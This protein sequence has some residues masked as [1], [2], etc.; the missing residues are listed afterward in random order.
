MSV[1]KITI[2]GDSGTGKSSIM[3]RYVNNTFDNNLVST[4][5]VEFMTKEI[6]VNGRNAK[7]QIWDTAGQER[8][9]AI[10]R[11]IYHGSKAIIIVYDITNSATFNSLEK[12]ISDSKVHLP[13]N[14]PYFLVGNKVDLDHLRDVKTQ[15]AKS[16]A[17]KFEM[18]F[19]ETSAATNQNISNIFEM[20]AKKITDDEIAGITGSLESKIQKDNKKEPVRFSDNKKQIK[21]TSKCDC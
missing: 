6:K 4:I 2:I 17:D 21:K 19:L 1:Y 16:F 12:W 3:E 10:S 11:S 9:R 5:G 13:P 15:T 20:I 8:F 7:L 14:T 18:S